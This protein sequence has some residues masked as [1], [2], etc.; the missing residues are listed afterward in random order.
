MAAF[1]QHWLRSIM[2]GRRKVSANDALHNPR[3]CCTHERE[4]EKHN[5]PKDVTIWSH[6]TVKPNP[7]YPAAR[8]HVRWHIHKRSSPIVYVNSQQRSSTTCLLVVL[9]PLLYHCGTAVLLGSAAA[10]VGIHKRPNGTLIRANSSI[11]LGPINDDFIVLRT[12]LR[13]LAQHGRCFRWFVSA[14]ADLRPSIFGRDVIAPSVTIVARKRFIWQKTTAAG[15]VA[16]QCTTIL[17]KGASY[18]A[19]Q[20]LVGANVTRTC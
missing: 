15:R 6:N 13:K 10:R 12:R 14:F 19:G 18:E 9:L 17:R 4:Y 7:I 1:Q 16:G 8:D 5:L 2:I 11:P 3:H 20:D